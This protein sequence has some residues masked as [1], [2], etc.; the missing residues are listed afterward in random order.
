MITFYD[1][2]GTLPGKSVTPN[3]R[4]GIP[5]RTECVE[6]PDIKAL[7]KTLGI[8]PKSTYLAGVT[9]HYCL[10]IIVDDQTGTTAA[11]SDSWDIAVYLDEAY[12]DAPR[13]FPKGTRALQAS[14]EQLWMETFA[15]GAAPL[16]IPRMPALLS[17]PSAEHF[18]RAVST[19]FAKEIG[20][21]EPQGEAR[22]Q[23]L[24]DWEKKLGK[25]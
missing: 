18:I 17:P 4:R 23:Y 20:K 16:L 1:I 2:P 15:Q 14:F 3:T 19:R 8:T 11:V 7:Y 12:P 9:P 22:V 24:K 13:L 5:F 25:S 21:F 10:P 6:A